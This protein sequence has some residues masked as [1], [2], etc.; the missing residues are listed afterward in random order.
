MTGSFQSQLLLHFSL[1]PA[2]LAAISPQLVAL[3]SQH[4]TCTHKSLTGAKQVEAISIPAHVK[5]R[6]SGILVCYCC[7][8]ST[9]RSE[10]K[11]VPNNV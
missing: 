8:E 2:Y 5:L 3:T 11:D 1:V 9:K 7:F 4:L 6:F 10:S